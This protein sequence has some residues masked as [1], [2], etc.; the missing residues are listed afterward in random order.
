MKKGN[1]S[2]KLLIDTR[3][4]K[5]LKVV[6]TRT[7][8]WPTLF[9]FIHSEQAKERW[10]CAHVFNAVVNAVRTMHLDGGTVHRDLHSKNIFVDV[11]GVAWDHRVDVKIFD[12]DRARKVHFKNAQ[13]VGSLSSIEFY[14][15]HATFDKNNKNGWNYND[16]FYALHDATV[17]HYAKPTLHAGNIAHARINNEVH[18]IRKLREGHVKYDKPAL[19]RFRQVRELSWA[20]DDGLDIHTMLCEYDMVFPHSNKFYKRLL[21]VRF[22][23][24]TGTSADATTALMFQHERMMARS[25]KGKTNGARMLSPVFPEQ[26]RCGWLIAHLHSDFARSDLAGTPA[27]AA[28]DKFHKQLWGTAQYSPTA[29]QSLMIYEHD[30]QLR[31]ATEV[32]ALD[33]MFNKVRVSNA[34]SS[35]RIKREQCAF[36][37]HLLKTQIATYA[38]HDDTIS[39]AFV[40]EGLGTLIFVDVKRLMPLQ[41]GTIPWQSW[42]R[43]F[44]L[45]RVAILHE[46]N[47]IVPKVSNISQWYVDKCTKFLNRSGRQ[48]SSVCSKVNASRARG[49]LAPQLNLNDK[50]AINATIQNIEREATSNAD[51]R[52]EAIHAYID[53]VYKNVAANKEADHDAKARQALQKLKDMSIAKQSWPYLARERVRKHYPLSSKKS[54]KAIDD[55]YKIA[56]LMKIAEDARGR[57]SKTAVKRARAKK[58]ITKRLV[59]NEKVRANFLNNLASKPEKNL[60]KT[61]NNII[62]SAKLKKNLAVTRL[63]RASKSYPLF[64]INDNSTILSLN[65][66]INAI[67]KGWEMT[68][69]RPSQLGQNARKSA[70]NAKVVLDRYTSNDTARTNP[71]VF[72]KHLNKM[73]RTEFHARLAEL[74]AAEWSAMQK[75]TAPERDAV[76]ML[77][78]F[79]EDEKHRTNELWKVVNPEANRDK[80]ILAIRAAIEGQALTKFNEWQSE[81]NASKKD[82]LL[83]DVM[84]ILK[85]QAYKKQV[86]LENKLSTHKYT[87]FYK[88]LAHSAGLDASSGAAFQNCLHQILENMQMPPPPLTSMPDEEHLK[89][90]AAMLRKPIHILYDDDMTQYKSGKYASRFKNTLRGMELSS[91]IY[92]N[93]RSNLRDAKKKT[94]AAHAKV[95]K[96]MH[97]NASKNAIDQARNRAWNLDQNVLKRKQVLNSLIGNQANAP[98][99]TNPDVIPLQKLKAILNG[100]ASSASTSL[101]WNA[102]KQSRKRAIKTL[103]SP[104]RE[105]PL[106][107]LIL[108]VRTEIGQRK[109]VG[110]NTDSMEGVLKALYAKQTLESK[111]VKAYKLKRRLLPRNKNSSTVLKRKMEAAEELK[112]SIPEALEI[113]RQLHRVHFY[114]ISMLISA[115]KKQQSISKPSICAGVRPARTDRLVAVRAMPDGT[116]YASMRA[117]NIDASLRQ[118]HA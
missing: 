6:A 33:K 110:A 47:A 42:V 91:N 87:D 102:V 18:T 51:E 40:N 7:I 35:D 70:T 111:A 106:R 15:A 61:S 80:E 50:N 31:N 78:K 100:N 64:E 62:R 27:L 1:R 72:K 79:M 92:A 39:N 81:S 85:Q 23:H 52:I 69:R 49:N 113:A 116:Y 109:A 21:I 105:P 30:V 37:D 103:P 97:Q 32:V 8:A 25:F 104:Q 60:N 38:T 19:Q 4:F 17:A 46:K 107:R 71:A 63:K 73:Q 56:P 112:N 67:K 94:A 68:G 58:A 117:L 13:S 96:L 77:G 14:N 83:N 84:R 76:D 114:T 98:V 55:I 22:A 54:K 93:E 89:I 48:L 10:L 99:R 95:R 82:K 3:F 53:L 65:A 115:L 108:D 34:L 16:G 12:F 26:G 45:N 118:R 9:D 75:A 57:T 59:N 5:D 29:Q 36:V 24:P 28:L 88:A 43:A 41:T 2:K 101:S 74:E 90:L 86:R 20:C 11:K 66:R 44:A